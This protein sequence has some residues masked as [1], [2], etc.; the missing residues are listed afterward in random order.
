MLRDKLV[1]GG[2]ALGV[3]LLLGC[4]G[5]PQKEVEAAQTALNDAKS[6]GAESYAAEEYSKAQE[7]LAQANAEVEAQKGRFVLMRSYGRAK[8]LLRQAAQ[9]AVAAKSA[10]EAGKVEAKS[11]AEV[12]IA[13]ARLAL[14][15]AVAALATAPAGKD[16]RADLEIMRGDL[17]ALKSTLGEADA[18][19]G[20]SDY[21][22][23]KERAEQVDQEARAIAADI[24]Q[25]ILKT[26]RR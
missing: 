16:S 19:F 1:F 6:T 17:D 22:T 10:A 23:A 4:A 14:D 21:A 24:E 15:A 8:Q 3:V 7:S 26:R 9:D 11:G 20:S 2:L 25:A 18:A 12:A 13:A 5:A